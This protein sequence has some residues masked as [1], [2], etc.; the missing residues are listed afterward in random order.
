MKLSYLK[1]LRPSKALLIVHLVIVLVACGSEKETNTEKVKTISE[2]EIETHLK[3][4]E[5]KKVYVF[6]NENAKREEY[7]PLVDYAISSLMQTEDEESISFLEDK[8]TSW[9]EARDYD[10]L[11]DYITSL[12]TEGNGDPVT[13]FLYEVEKYME[14]EVYL[15]EQK[16]KLPVMKKQHDDLVKNFPYPVPLNKPVLDEFSGTILQ[17]IN[18]LEYRVLHNYSGEQYVL[19]TFETSFESTGRFTMN[20]LFGEKKRYNMDN[21]FSKSFYVLYEIPERQVETIKNIIGLREGIPEKEKAIKETEQLIEDSVP[22]LKV[23]LSAVFDTRNSTPSP[24]QEQVEKERAVNSEIEFMV[25]ENQFYI[26][27]ITLQDSEKF[28]ASVFGQP[29][30]S[31]EDE[32]GESEIINVYDGIRIGYFNEK[33]TSIDFEISYEDLEE[34]V[35]SEYP[36][37]KLVNED[38]DVFLYNEESQ[39]LL[40]VKSYAGTYTVYLGYADNIFKEELEYGNIRVQN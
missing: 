18:E 8:F 39:H 38:G 27:G 11:H 40:M 17:K 31:E 10:I 19:R 37:D 4:R 20:V 25:K 21:G 13:S 33:V 28:V 35:I 9:I 15:E 1:I 6:I 14:E 7:K 3:N 22:Y 30:S 34:Q 26:N 29:T 2:D 32:L 23:I 5:Y 12:E 36:G 16:A 24:V